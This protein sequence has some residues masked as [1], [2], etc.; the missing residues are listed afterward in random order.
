MP[1]KRSWELWFR[2][3]FS[4]CFVSFHFRFDFVMILPTIKVM[5][6]HHHPIAEES[7]CCPAFGYL[8]SSAH[9][10]ECST[11]FEITNVVPAM[12]HSFPI[13]P[14]LEFIEFHLLSAFEHIWLSIYLWK[15]KPIFNSIFVSPWRLCSFQVPTPFWMFEI[16]G[17]APTPIFSFSQTRSIQ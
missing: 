6:N 13:F 5:K 14:K 15:N 3:I 2:S 8:I 12:E 4:D 17:S 7:N 16:F 9:V 11:P 10:N 1:E